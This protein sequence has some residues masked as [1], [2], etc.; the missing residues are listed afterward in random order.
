MAFWANMAILAQAAADA[1]DGL[2]MWDVGLSV[3][4]F[5]FVF[6]LVIGIFSQGGKVHMS[7]QREAA[8]A[9]GHLDRKTVFENPYLRPLMWLLLMASY[10]LSADKLKQW[11]HRKL[12]AAGSPNYYTS[13]EYLA[14]ALLAALGMGL[15]MVVLGLLLNGELSAIMF[16]IGFA[17]GFGLML[18]QIMDKASKRVRAISRRVPYSLDLVSLAMGAGAT[19]VEAVRTIVRENTDDPFNVELK[20]LLAE[21]D[22]GTTRRKALQNLADR[23]PLESLRGIVASIIQAEELGTPLADVMHSQATLLRLQRSVKAENAAAVASVRIL[24]PSLLIL[25]GVVLAVI[26][27]SIIKAIKGGLF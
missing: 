16:L 10:R 3:G 1:E 13:E 23:V 7:P 15:I 20:S 12:V 4:L 8:L 24:V 26:A 18:Y 25:M 9:T 27:P 21:I 14:L 5:V 17:A 11:V 19:F 2:S 22:L 6:L